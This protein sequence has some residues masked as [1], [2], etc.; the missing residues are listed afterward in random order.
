M[1]K[2]YKLIFVVL[3]INTLNADFLGNITSS[4]SN[5]FKNGINGNDIYSIFDNPELNDIWSKFGKYPSNL[6]QLCYSTSY[7]SLGSIDYDLCSLA[8]I[9][10]PCDSLPGSLGVLKKRNSSSMEEKISSL[11]NWCNS[12]NE[13]KKAN[14]TIEKANEQ[15]G[16]SGRTKTETR[17]KT[18]NSAAKVVKEKR[19]AKTLQQY[20]SVSKPEQNSYAEKVVSLEKNGEGHIV[21]NEIKRLGENTEQLSVEDLDK[22]KD[23]IIF[24]DYKEYEDDLNY[25]TSQDAEVERQLFDFSNHI[26]IANQQFSTFNSQGKTYQDKINFIEDY[27]ENEQKGIRQNYYKFAELKAEEEIMYIVPEKIDNKYYIFNEKNLLANNAYTKYDNK[28][29]Q[30]A[31][32]NEDIVKQQYLEKEIMLKHRTIANDKAD[33]L[34][35]LL[36]KNALAS[37]IF[38]REAALQRIKQMIN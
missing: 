9:P 21:R 4:G 33:E 19:V 1:K 12:I 10:N 3:M 16:I 29:T 17:N 6:V 11:K 24:N 35:N 20:K 13:D 18:F 30:V 37:E 26:K 27:I 23:K 28:K 32:I 38:D 5:Y 8:N 36:I 14:D 25:K 34:K 22:V 7:P 2:S 15:K 31:L